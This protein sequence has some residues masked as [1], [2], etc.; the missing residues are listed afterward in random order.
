MLKLNG[1]LWNR[2]YLH[3]VFCGCRPPEPK[4][5]VQRGLVG[6]LLIERRSHSARELEHGR[7]ACEP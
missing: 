5:P 2:S 6:I 3:L 1:L 4:W 7:R